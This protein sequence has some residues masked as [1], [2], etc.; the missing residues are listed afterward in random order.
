MNGPRSGPLSGLRVIELGGIGPVPMCGMLLS[1]LGADVIR[2]ERLEAADLGIPHGRRFEILLRGRRSVALDLK[3][4]EGRRIVL[5][6]TETAH[7]LI[8]GFRPGVTER[9]GLGPDDCFGANPS[10]VYGRMTGFGQ[11]GPLA[12]AA[13]HDINYIALTGALAAIGEERPLPPLN[14]V[15]DFGG[16]GLYLALGVCAALLEAKTSG[17]G[18]VV[19]A[20]MV[21]GAAS[22]MASI[23][24]LHAAGLWTEERGANLLDGGA[25]FYGTYQCADE[26]WIAIGPLEQR[27]YDLMLDV[28]ELDGDVLP[29]RRS[30]ADWPELRSIFERAFKRRTRAEWIEILEGTDVCFA[31]V[32]SMTEAPGHPHNSARDTF[33]EVDGITQPGP[34]PRFSRTPGAIQGPV[35]A[36]GAHTRAVL[37]ELG[38]TPKEIQRLE[39]AGVISPA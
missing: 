32:L 12:E 14:L 20:A 22:L 31:P 30:P 23:Y 37:D 36:R 13:G 39:E 38:W 27:F 29:D 3:S 18:Q 6:L 9:M 10:L 28:L 33:V 7:A 21:D 26:E 2:V 35:P 11:E 5:A 24:G 4:D 16:G 15:G 17:R 1:D 34:A 25:P 19:D 8:E